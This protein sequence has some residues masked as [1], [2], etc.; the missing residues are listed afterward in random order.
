MIVRGVSP[1]KYTQTTYLSFA[2]Q[3]QCSEVLKQFC[4]EVMSEIYNNKKI[5]KI[6]KYEAGGDA[7]HVYFFT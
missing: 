3:L 5:Q 4:F 6:P 2:K 1:Q 7:K